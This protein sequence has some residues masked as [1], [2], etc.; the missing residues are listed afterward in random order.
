MA[1]GITH[2][3]KGLYRLCFLFFVMVS[4]FHM[5]RGSNNDT[6]RNQ[7][8][9][10]HFQ[11]TVLT[12]YHPS[13]KAKYSGAFSLD[14]NS[15]TTTS[16]TASVFF[17]LRLWKG[18][19][20][21]FDPELSGGSGFSQTR[22]IAGFPNGEVYRVSDASPHIYIARLYFRQ[23]FALSK[24]YHAVADDFNQLAGMEPDSY[25]SLIGGK[26]SMMDFFDNNSYSHDPRTQFYNWALMGN[27]A[28]DYPANTRGYTYGLALEYVNPSWAMRFAFVTMPKVANGSDMQ[29][30]VLTSN[31]AALEFEKNYR[32]GQR[33]GRFSLLAYLNTGPM[34][35][36]QQAIDM[37]KANDTAPDIT[38]VRTGGH[39]KYGF[40]LNA[41]QEL[42]KSVGVFLR[43]SWNDGLNET[44]VFTEI[45]R[46]LTVGVSV[47]G[48]L[49]HRKD[50]V[51]GS[52]VILNDISPGHRN[53]LKAGGVGFILGDGTLT[54][55]NELIFEAYY[56]F[57]FFN[58]LLWITPDYQFI[59]NPGYNQ[60]RGPVHAFGVRVHIEI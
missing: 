58:K 33:K 10:Y 16:V 21:Y 48:D 42:G 55:G 31:A 30:D 52:A 20:V 29:F 22:G 43:S 7:R 13:F 14:T 41:E 50:D 19:Q 4:F 8:W 11:T 57:R 18:A 34:G 54:Y 5:V 35:N 25:I 23:L 59:V 15:E 45:D 32:I 60:D 2:M 49:W 36:Y 3:K 12:Q 26:F 1:S 9:N 6:I 47:N 39:T 27:G 17:G 44:W 56:D 53:Y 28:W 24:T 38:K 46:T 37:G 51:F 40:G